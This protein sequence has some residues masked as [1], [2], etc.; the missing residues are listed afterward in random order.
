MIAYEHKSQLQ[1]PD[2]LGKYKKTKTKKFGNTSLSY[3]Q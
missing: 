3:Y 2:T 1:M